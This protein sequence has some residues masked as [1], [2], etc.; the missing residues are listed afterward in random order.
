[1]GKGFLHAVGFGVSLSLLSAGTVGASEAIQPGDLA[2]TDFTSL[3]AVQQAEPVITPTAD[4]IPP[5]PYI[6]PAPQSW[7]WAIT[8]RAWFSIAGTH[9]FQD[10]PQFQFSNENVF[11]PLFGGS[12][13]IIPPT[14]SGISFSTTVF[15]GTGSGDFRAVGFE[16]IPIPIFPF[17]AVLPFNLEG[18]ND[19]ERLDI[20]S[21]VQVPIAEGVTIFGGGRYIRVKL[22]TDGDIFDTTGLL[23]GA[24]GDIGDFELK[25]DQKFYLGEL[26][27]GVTRPI[28]AEGRWVAF[29]NATAM[30]GVADGDGG[31]TF[32]VIGAPPGEFSGDQDLNGPVFGVDANA[33]VGFRPWSNALLSAR[34]RLFVISDED[35]DFESGLGVVHGPE[36]NLTITFP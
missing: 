32:E 12:L 30:F 28:D 19:V 10:S 3:A 4:F 14:A 22:D 31:G 35:V 1:M 33:G 17:S 24:G 25:G 15:Y 7:V 9:F 21:I 27:L 34:Y 36:V 26:G 16:E 20:E 5:E 13:T 2:P 23:G 8:P 11:L 29:G 18:N 6:E